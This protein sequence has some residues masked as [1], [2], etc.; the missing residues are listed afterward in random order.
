MIAGMGHRLL[1]RWESLAA[2]HQIAVLLPVS[3][4]VLVLIHLVFF[5]H[6][7]FGRSLMYAVMEAL[8]LTLLLVLVTQAEVARRRDL[9]GGGDGDD[10]G[11]S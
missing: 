8:P 6:L 10:D 4:V 9:E 2:R 7:T 11:V 1:R 3:L 5:P